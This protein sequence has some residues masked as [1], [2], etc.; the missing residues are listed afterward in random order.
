MNSSP[1]IAITGVGAVCGSGLEVESIWS[2]IQA[3][4]SAVTA[5]RNWNASDWP[6]GIAAEV[7]GVSNQT[8]VEDRKLHK[9]ISR[10]DLFGLYAAG[11]A[12][13]QSGVIEF[14]KRLS[15]TVAAGFNDRCGVF[16]GSG[17]GAYQG[18]YEFFPL[19]T[20]AG[21]DLGRFGRELCDTVSP[22]W[23]LKHL[24]NNVLCHVGI[25]HGFKGTNACITNHCVGGAMAV[26]EAAHAIR[27][28]EADRAIAIG[29]DAPIEPETV[30]HFQRLGLLAHDTVRPFDQSRSGTVLG[31][32]AAA[33]LLETE[34]DARER[35]AV[36]LGEF[37]GSGCVTEGTGVLDVRSDGEGLSR[38]I[39]L[40]LA[41]AGMSPASV[42]MI[43]AHGN[44]TRASDASEA[45]AIRRVFGDDLPPI[46]AFKWSFGHL[47]SGSGVIDLLLA[48]TCLRQRIVPGIPT[49]RRL[50]P[51]LAPLP[52]SVTPQQPR[53]DKALVLCRG[54]GGMN[55]ALLVR[56][57]SSSPAGE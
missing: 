15:A 25:R 14:R 29:H 45:I 6:I 30:L 56:A 20:A 32:G 27:H 54:F 5:I 22:M 40:A 37:L 24:P 12:I 39:E 19:M 16:V 43:V 41:D 46:T 53:G 17:G 9:S 7:C 11:V 1:R 3:G 34:A 57:A 33:V 13:R 48:L 44:G 23:L 55:V 47:I 52:V 31:E 4:R 8:L 28:A 26:G 18:H 36:V 2:A 21:G 49:L 42:G 35:G 51:S 38:A 50:D 10:T